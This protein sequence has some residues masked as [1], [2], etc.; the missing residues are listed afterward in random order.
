MERKTTEVVCP[1]HHDTSGHTRRRDS[2][3]LA[4]ACLSRAS[5]VQPPA[6]QD[7]LAGRQPPAK[8]GAAGHLCEGGVSTEVAGG[9]SSAAD[10]CSRDT[11]LIRLPSWSW[12]WP[13]FYFLV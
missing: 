5:T 10:T 2:S 12:P 13:S 1:A 4:E 9:N 8:A 3:L 7:F 6:P 11:L